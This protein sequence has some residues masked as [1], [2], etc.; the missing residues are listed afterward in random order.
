VSRAAV[1]I[2]PRTVGPTASWYWTEWRWRT[3]RVSAEFEGER[4]ARGGRT[5]FRAMAR[6]RNMPAA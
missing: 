3:D 6:K 5:F 2:A 1:T 4:Q